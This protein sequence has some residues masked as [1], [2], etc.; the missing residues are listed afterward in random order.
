MTERE[1]SVLTDVERDKLFVRTAALQM[2]GAGKVIVDE[3]WRHRVPLIL[4]A[5][6]VLFPP[7]LPGWIAFVVLWS[8]FEFIYSKLPEAKQ[9]KV[10]QMLPTFSQLDWVKE[11]GMGVTQVRPFVLFSVYLFCA[12]FA[13]VW[14]LVHWVGSFKTRE[15]DKKLVEVGEC[16]SIVVVQ[17][18]QPVRSEQES[19]FFHSPVFGLTVLLTFCSGIPAAVSYLLYFHLG[20]DALFGSLSQDPKFNLIFLVIGLYIAS[21]GWCLSLLFLR[22]WFT[23]PT[24]FLSDER[25]VEFNENGIRRHSPRGWFSTVLTLNSPW[26]GAERLD[27]IDTVELRYN[28]GSGMRFYPLPEHPFEPDSVIYKVLNKFAA[29]SDGVV[30][31]I[32]RAEFIEFV[33]KDGACIKLNLWELNGSERARLFYA[34]RK[35][36]PHVQSDLLLQEKLLGSRVLSAPRYTQ[37]WFD[38]LSSSQTRQ[39]LNTLQ[40][41]DT[42]KDGRITIEQRIGTGGQATVYR[43]IYADRFSCVL[44]EFVLSSADTVGALIESAADFDNEAGLLSRLSHPGIVKLIDVF[45]EDRRV[46]LMLEEVP[47][48]SLRQLVQSDGAMCESRVLDIAVQACEILKYLH[49]QEPPLVHRDISPDNLV[50]TPDGI[51]KLIDFSLATRSVNSSSEEERS[52]T[53]TRSGCVGKFG[54]TPPEQFREEVYPQSDIY[55]LGGTIHYLLTGKDPK[56][57]TQSIPSSEKEGPSEGIDSIVRRATELQLS[58][59]YENVAWM[60]IDLKECSEKI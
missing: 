54:Y 51:V 29:F 13:L 26:E 53:I 3:I 6:L 55:A 59:R 28:S 60:L 39:R 9:T 30:D 8:L 25:K 50:L 49:E 36:A 38:L 58:A 1:V 45:T 2:A 10:K 44:K 4:I 42:L 35:W 12:P 20:M 14:M 46:Y 57:L 19:N 17:N 33:G 22:A 21:I 47:G 7:L 40:S 32:G 5:G 56:P 37:I 24:N 23:F 16:K 18:K 52:A 15:D 34:V 48:K 11:L 31:R 43:A 41:G 27:W